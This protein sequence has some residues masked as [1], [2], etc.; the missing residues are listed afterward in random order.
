MSSGIWALLALVIGLVG[1][2]F[3][4]RSSNAGFRRSVELDQELQRVRTELE[5][6]RTNV[7]EHFTTTVNLVNKLTADYRAVYNHL[8]R[9]AQQL[10][11]GH[12]PQFDPLAST[13]PQLMAPP[14]MIDELLEEI[15]EEEGVSGKARPEVP[16][17]RTSGS[18][19]WYEDVVP[20]TEIPRYAK[21][22]QYR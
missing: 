3:V 11:G 18:E 9:G 6:F 13:E 22:D 8:S 10:A 17:R 1:G 12:I 5:G 14:V 4:G 7:V 20:G 21:N 15:D 16:Q 2:F 19:G